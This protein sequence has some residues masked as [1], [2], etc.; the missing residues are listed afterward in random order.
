M[1]LLTYPSKFQWVSHL[2][3]VTAATLLT[4]GQPNFAQCLAVFWASTLYIHFWGLL[5]TDGILPGAKFTL[6]PSLAFY[7]GSVTA[8]HSSS[9]HLWQAELTFIPFFGYPK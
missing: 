7:V 1:K 6:H 5:P 4:A 2:G 9:E 3:F 8:W